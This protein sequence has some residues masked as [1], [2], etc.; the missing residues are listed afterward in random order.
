LSANSV[1]AEFDRL[2]KGTCSKEDIVHPDIR[3]RTWC[4]SCS[5]PMLL[6]LFSVLEKNRAAP[7]RPAIRNR[8]SLAREFLV[9][10]EEIATVRPDDGRP[11]RRNGLG[12]LTYKVRGFL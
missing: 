8:V 5:R 3:G 12:F 11:L 6:P 4:Q 9:E 2:E 7:T 10:N 1:A